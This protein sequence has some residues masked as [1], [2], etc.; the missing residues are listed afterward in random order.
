MT[1]FIP[2]LLAAAALAA[3]VGACGGDSGGG[4]GGGTSADTR[5]AGIKFARCMRENGID[6]PDPTGGGG[7]LQIGPESGIDLDSEKFR[8]AEAACREEAPF[9]PGEEA[10][11]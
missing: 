5:D 4:A 1:R 7:V 11:P 3:G 9:G 10:S 8:E 6:F 2:T